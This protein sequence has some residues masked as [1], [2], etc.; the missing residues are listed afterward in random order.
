M[1]HYAMLLAFALLLP[2]VGSTTAEANRGAAKRAAKAP[3]KKAVAAKTQRPKKAA[4]KVP[5]RAAAAKAKPLTPAK[6]V[7]RTKKLAE[8]YA[9]EHKLETRIVKSGPN[10]KGVERVFVP[11]LPETHASF[12]KKFTTVGGND[13]VLL[14]YSPVGMSQAHLVL[15]MKPGDIYLWAQNKNLGGNGNVFY[16]QKYMQ[17]DGNAQEWPGYS[18]AVHPNSIKALQGF[19]TRE[20]KTPTFCGGNCMRWLPNAATGKDRTLF[21]DLGIKRSLDG[22]NMTAK[23]LHAANHRVGVI[24]VHVT[25]LAQFKAMTNEQLM[26]PQPKGGIEA[27]IRE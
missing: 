27:A 26:G 8:S 7:A 5:L 15:A 10:G 18:I 25:S 19:L 22:T 11:V 2:A 24:G 9:K 21:H 20:A 23:I 14:R 6:T 12:Q 3:V 1:R 17:T 13:S 4:T 16:Q